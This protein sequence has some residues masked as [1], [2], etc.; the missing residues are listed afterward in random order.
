MFYEC[1]SLETLNLG[2]KFDTKTEGD[3]LSCMFYCCC[4]LN[5]LNCCASLEDCEDNVI[6]QYNI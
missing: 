6:N 1:K 5:T 4:S 3:N 2:D